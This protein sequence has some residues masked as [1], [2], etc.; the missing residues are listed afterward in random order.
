MQEKAA[1]KVALMYDTPESKTYQLLCNCGDPEHNWVVDIELDKQ[2]GTQVTIYGDVYYYDNYYIGEFPS[3]LWQ[4]I[5]MYWKRLGAVIRL[6][7]TGY[8]KMNTDLLIL[9]EKHLDSFIGIL[10]EGRA[11]W[12]KRKENVKEESNGKGN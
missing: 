8:L 3:N 1:Y 5:T 6:L 4:R 10:E 7:F 2:W 12:L 9:D 11:Y